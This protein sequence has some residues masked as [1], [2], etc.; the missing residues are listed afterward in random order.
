MLRCHPA[1][2]W[3]QARLAE[4]GLLVL[5]FGVRILDGDRQ[6]LQLHQR[7]ADR[8]HPLLRAD[9][10]QFNQARSRTRLR[11]GFAHRLCCAIQASR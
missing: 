4:Q 11:A 5:G 8:V 10:G 3:R 2:G 9:Q 1:R 7:I 6:R